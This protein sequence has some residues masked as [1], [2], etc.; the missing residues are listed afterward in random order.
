[1][2]KTVIAVLL[3]ILVAF[4]IAPAAQAASG[5]VPIP[6]GT[7][8]QSDIDNVINGDPSG[9]TTR[10]VLGADCTFTASAT[11]VPRN[12]DEVVCAIQPGFIQRANAWDP[13]PRCTIEGFTLPQVMKPQGDIHMAGFTCRGGAFTGAA[14][15][16]VCIAEGQMSDSSGLWGVEVRDTEGA[17]IS[18]AHGVHHVIEL[19]NT[20]TNSRALGFI[21]SGIKGVNEFNIE[22]SYV[23]DNQ[24]NGIWCDNE[25]KDATQGP[26]SV[27]H[28]NSNLVVD[29]GREG[30]RWE[31][32]GSEANHGEALIEN[33]E[34]YG[35]GRLETRAGIS[36]RDAQDALI[37]Q[38]Y[39]WNN[40]G[41]AIRASD[42]GRT[43]RPN[44]LNIDIVN[45]TLY[46]GQ[47]TGCELPD[48][49]V[50]C[51]GNAP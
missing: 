44:L 16:G 51:F 46:G 48:E 17:G 13:Q 39:F 23:H 33:N 21:G 20:T 45:N 30:I 29:N 31:R 15:T 25:C 6:C 2:R 49:I 40:S 9:T 50:Y 37:R 35:N 3:V 4:V 43:D 11:L 5:T 47:I 28:V 38:N 1:M 10:F 14:G 36:A 22:H 12:G 26:F 19:T 7:G 18:N 24:G 42:S 32:V 8:P 34:V 27:F 41:G